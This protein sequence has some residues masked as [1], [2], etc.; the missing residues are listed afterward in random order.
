MILCGSGDT[1]TNPEF[2]SL[3]QFPSLGAEDKILV[4]FE[5]ANHMIFANDCEAMDW[6]LDIGAFWICSD[7]VWDMDRAPGLT[8]HFTTA[9]LL[10][11]LKDDAEA[12]AVLAPDAVTFPGIIYET[13]MGE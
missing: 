8:N 1:V 7:P 11:T 4:T 13:T 2:N 9:F 3:A 5:N 12:A 10:A 6:L